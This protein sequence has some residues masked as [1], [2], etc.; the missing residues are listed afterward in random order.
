[1]VTGKVLFVQQV[2]RLFE[3]LGREGVRSTI[4]LNDMLVKRVC[5]LFVKRFTSQ[6]VATLLVIRIPYT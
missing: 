5:Q 6:P 2:T 1:M 4:Q 3:V